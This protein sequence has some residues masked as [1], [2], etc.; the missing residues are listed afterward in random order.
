MS[1]IRLPIRF[2]G[3]L[4]ERN[5]YALFDTGASYSGIRPDLA[6]EIAHIEVL[7]KPMHFI[8]ARAGNFLT[9]TQRICS[10]FYLEE[11]RLSD[12]FLVIPDLSEEVIIG[13]NT[14]QKWRI[15][16]GFEL[17]R[18]VIEERIAKLI[19]APRL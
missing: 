16:L 15:K 4:G 12:E 5:L 14:L 10:E 6:E 9:V 2:E 13:V 11:L 8:T 17:E 1:I 7:P 18:P 19:M 3:S